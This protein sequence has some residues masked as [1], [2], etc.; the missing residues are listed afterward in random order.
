M[1]LYIFRLFSQVIMQFN[2][3]QH[4]FTPYLYIF[5]P[6]WANFIALVPKMSK[7]SMCLDRGK[8]LMKL[9]FIHMWSRLNDKQGE[10][11]ASHDEQVKGK[12]AGREGGREA[13]RN[14]EQEKKEDVRQAGRSAWAEASNSQQEGIVAAGRK[15]CE[16]ADDEEKERW[17]EIGR[18]TW[19]D[20]DKEMRLAV[21][22]AGREAWQ[23]QDEVGKEAAKVSQDKAETSKFSQNLQRYTSFN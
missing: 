16:D 4:Y 22:E 7:I 23:A 15:A 9:L 20:L 18:K 2:I 1:I 8:K 6:N 17:K 13:F 5:M 3:F 10:D 21:L 14:F 12:V 11:D 19:H